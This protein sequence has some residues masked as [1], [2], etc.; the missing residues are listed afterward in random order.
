MIRSLDLYAR[1]RDR[2]DHIYIYIY[3]FFFF[4]F[5]GLEGEIRRSDE[6]RRAHK[7]RG[8]WSMVVGRATPPRRW[9][10]P[11]IEAFPK[12]GRRRRRRR[13][14]RWRA[15]SP[16]TQIASKPP[17]ARFLRSGNSSSRF[18]DRLHTRER[19]SI[20]SSSLRIRGGGGEGRKKGREDETVTNRWSEGSVNDS[21]GRNG[22]EELEG[23]P[24][25]RNFLLP[26]SSARR[27]RQSRD[28]LSNAFVFR[29]P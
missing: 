2:I 6:R 5:S 27:A 21:H 8:W 1:D 7:W 18:L 3:I 15:T 12:I 19:C 9:S 20:D 22:A 13:R 26:P 29:P 28:Q 25:K 17:K 4:W 23:W 24:G 14:R 11:M 10:G 16:A